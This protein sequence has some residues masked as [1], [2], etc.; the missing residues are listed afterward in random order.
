V[1]IRNFKKLFPP[2]PSNPNAKVSEY[3]MEAFLEKEL[4]G[5]L[6]TGGKIVEG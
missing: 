1:K 3:T 4:G 6:W 2:H 5:D